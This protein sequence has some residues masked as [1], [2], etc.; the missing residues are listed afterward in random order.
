MLVT[1]YNA[2]TPDLYPNN[3]H[4]KIGWILTWV[5]CAQ[6]V[7]AIARK[8]ARRE[9]NKQA[10]EQTAFIPICAESMAEHERIHGLARVQGNRFSGDSGQGTE[11]NTESLR[12]QSISSAGSDD[13]DLSNVRVAYEAEDNEVEKLCLLTPSKLDRFLSK[14]IP[15]LLSSRALGIFHF[16]YNFIDRV[17]LPLGFLVLTTGIITYGGLFVS[18]VLA[19]S[20]QDCFNIRL[21][22]KRG[23]QWACTFYKGW[24]F[25]LVWHPYT[26]T[27]GRVLC[28]HWLG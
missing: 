7:M 9:E 19:H 21:D 1:I 26:C 22:G 10:E 15:A 14:K 2:N 16:A 5:I 24:C 25:L 11:R 18:D 27:L 8:Y 23:L 28:R 12:S 13:H 17:I 20:L 3:A 4:H 6:T